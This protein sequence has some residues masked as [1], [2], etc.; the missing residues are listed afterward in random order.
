MYQAQGSTVKQN[1]SPDCF[2]AHVGEAESRCLSDWQHVQ[3]DS[4][5]DLLEAIETQEVFGRVGSSESL[6]SLGRSVLCSNGF[7]HGSVE[8]SE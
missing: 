4:A 6:P 3:A 8:R 5:V 1:K 7:F 2:L